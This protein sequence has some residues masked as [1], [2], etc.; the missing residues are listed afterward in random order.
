MNYPYVVIGAG[1]GGLVIAI[2]LTKAG[3]KI[4]LIERGHWG[5]GCTNF[6]CIPSKSL[7]A[8]SVRKDPGAFEKV[9]KIV[10]EMKRYETPE[11]LNQFG[12]F[13]KIASI[14]P[15]YPAYA[16]TI[17]KAADMWLTQTL[18]PILMR[19]KK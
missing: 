18:L 13:R 5:G 14:I 3:K 10:Q 1:V 4:L 7:I 12:V 11:A 8:A 17:W 19:K 16:L 6:G 9:R 15:P 2:G